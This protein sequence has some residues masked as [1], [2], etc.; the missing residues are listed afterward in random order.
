MCYLNNNK[1]ACHDNV[2]YIVNSC[3]P[4]STFHCDITGQPVS[5]SNSGRN[6]YAFSC[7]F[8]LY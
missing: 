3:Q 1:V 8:F 5:E 7:G 2:R 6:W 4:K